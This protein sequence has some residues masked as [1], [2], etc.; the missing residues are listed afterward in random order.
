MRPAAR[1]TKRGPRSPQAL[2]PQRSARGACSKPT[3]RSAGHRSAGCRLRRFVAELA[4]ACN[5]RDA[6]PEQMPIRYRVGRRTSRPA[7]LPVTS[8][9][10]SHPVRTSEENPSG[11]RSI[12]RHEQ[13]LHPRPSRRHAPTAARG[14]TTRRPA[15]Q[16]EL[17]APLRAARTAG[18]LEAAAAARLRARGP[19]AG[20][21]DRPARRDP[22]VAARARTVPRVRGSLRHQPGAARTRGRMPRT[23]TSSSATPYRSRPEP[24]FAQPR[25][26]DARPQP[27]ARH[28]RSPRDA[29]TDP[30]AAAARPRT[31]DQR[32][33]APSPRSPPRARRRSPG[34]QRTEL[35]A[36]RADARP[37]RRKAASQAAYRARRKLAAALATGRA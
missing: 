30:E 19:R 26:S 17:R 4:Q 7:P 21:Q 15:A 29:R 12:R 37:A 1:P 22:R 20:G 5:R 24:A 10:L 35:R 25:P 8:P 28:A 9:R 33:A 16:E 31:A 18:R 36:A 23:S 6:R 3:P 2:P 32:A 34:A 27:A 13:H 14:R 11:A